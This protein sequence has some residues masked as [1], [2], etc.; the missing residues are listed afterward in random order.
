M[1]LRISILLLLVLMFCF[2]LSLT[3]DGS[4]YSNDMTI[5]QVAHDVGLKGRELAEKF[6]LEGSVDK[7][8][9]LSEL[10]VSQDQ[11]EAVLAKLPAPDPASCPAPPP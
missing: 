10:G 6:G 3:A 2:G 5:R 8:T 11:L 7:D 1:N 9:A 4:S